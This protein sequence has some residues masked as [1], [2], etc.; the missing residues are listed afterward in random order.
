M[1]VDIHTVGPHPY[2]LTF[3]QSFSIQ[4]IVLSEMTTNGIRRSTVTYVGR[5]WSEC[6]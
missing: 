4:Y 5:W 3:L 1:W 2:T 6:M